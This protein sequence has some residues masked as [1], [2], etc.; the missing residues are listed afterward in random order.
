MDE[1]PVTL[2]NLFNQLGLESDEAAIEQFIADHM[3]PVDVKLV[4]APFWSP[5]QA[6][7]LKEQLLEDALWATAVDELNARLHEPPHA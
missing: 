5:A 7:F 4:E 3:L 1:T 6:D 2:E